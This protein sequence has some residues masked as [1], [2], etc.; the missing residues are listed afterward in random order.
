MQPRD[1]GVGLALH[2]VLEGECGASGWQA[3]PLTVQG[4]ADVSVRENEIGPH[5]A[6]LRKSAFY[7]EAFDPLKMPAIV[8]KQR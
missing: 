4:L 8:C 2:G 5:Y 1:V 3:D 7:S 6:C